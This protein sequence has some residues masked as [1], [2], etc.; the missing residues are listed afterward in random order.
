MQNGG[1]CAKVEVISSQSSSRGE[2]VGQI[3]LDVESRSNIINIEIQGEQLIC[4]LI[5]G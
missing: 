1:N 4:Q 5:L 3:L 2:N